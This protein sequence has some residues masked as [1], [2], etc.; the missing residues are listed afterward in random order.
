MTRSSIR[1]RAEITEIPQAVERLLTEGQGAITQIA[2]AVKNSD[3]R[4]LLSVPLSHVR[5][6]H[7]MTNPI[8]AIVS[9]YKMVETVATARGI[10]PDAPRHLKKVTETV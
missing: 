2:A 9:F 1:M 6:N 5:Q 10:N 4:F 7:W 3:I 8:A